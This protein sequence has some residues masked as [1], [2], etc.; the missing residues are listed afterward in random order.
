MKKVMEGAIFQGYHMNL[1]LLSNLD[2]GGPD[3]LKSDLRGHLRLLRPL[4]AAEAKNGIFHK[5]SNSDFSWI[6]N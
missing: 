6:P 2:L 3:D 4:E 1:K 5:F